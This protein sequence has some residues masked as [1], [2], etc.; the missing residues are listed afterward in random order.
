MADLGII[1]LRRKHTIHW[2]QSLFTII[3]GSMPFRYFWATLY[4]SNFYF[5]QLT[6]V[7]T[8]NLFLILSLKFSFILQDN[9][10]MMIWMQVEDTQNTWK[11]VRRWGHQLSHV[12]LHIDWN[13]SLKITMITN[14]ISSLFCSSSIYIKFPLFH[15]KCFTLSVELT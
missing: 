3:T 6:C 9:S 2:Y 15:L 4:M 7:H 13:V 12:H 8:L 10:V 11:I 1:F 5:N 14:F